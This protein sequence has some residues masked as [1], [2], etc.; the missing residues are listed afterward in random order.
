[1]QRARVAPV[2]EVARGEGLVLGA[3]TQQHEARVLVLVLVVRVLPDVADQ[4]D[5]SERVGASDERLG[6]GGR[7]RA[8][9]VYRRRTKVPVV[10]GPPR[11]GVRLADAIDV[12][13]ALE[14]VRIGSVPF[15]L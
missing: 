4:V 3:A 10:L 15:D 12:R 7:G 13:L 8:T 2:L 9:A 11:V 5:E 6:V 1:M 14:A